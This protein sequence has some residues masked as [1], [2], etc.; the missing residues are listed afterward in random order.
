MA[1]D[2]AP[3]APGDGAEPEQDGGHAQDVTNARRPRSADVGRAVENPQLAVGWGDF[4]DVDD[5]ES[6]EDFDDEPDEEPDD[7]SLDEVDEESLDEP[8]ELL[9][10]AAGSDDACLPRLS[11]R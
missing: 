1:Q 3:H 4:V 6:P 10:D 9:E 7:E 8:D 2:G 5:D 11:L